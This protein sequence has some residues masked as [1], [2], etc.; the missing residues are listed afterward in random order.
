MMESG[1]TIVL[2]AN[3]APIIAATAPIAVARCNLSPACVRWEREK[4]LDVMARLR[5]LQT[6]RTAGDGR[7]SNRKNTAG[8]GRVPAPSPCRATAIAQQLSREY[9]N[10]SI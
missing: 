3:N 7:T 9:D 2:P 8:V 5:R 1:V 10:T 4:S 6:S